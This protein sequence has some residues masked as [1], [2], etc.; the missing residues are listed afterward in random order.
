MKPKKT[1]KCGLCPFISTETENKYSRR[2]E[3]GLHLKYHRVKLSNNITDDFATFMKKEIEENTLTH[4]CHFE[5]C[6]FTFKSEFVYDQRLSAWKQPSGWS[7]W[8]HT[9]LSVSLLINF[10]HHSASSLEKNEINCNLRSP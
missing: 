1:Y 3:F 7:F 6:D 4:K 8:P 2:F 5:G 9:Y 10:L